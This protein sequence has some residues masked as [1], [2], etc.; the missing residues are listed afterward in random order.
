MSPST[1]YL[2]STGRGGAGNIRPVTK[3]S[4]SPTISLEPTSA[5]SSLF[6]GIGGAGNVVSR[7]EYDEAQR[8]ASLLSSRPA[9]L[10]S[11]ISGRSMFGIGGRGNSVSNATCS[12]KTGL[13]GGEC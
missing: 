3:A 7:N 8:S 9:S 6:R 2:R 12:E 4:T 11:L 5:R 13:E 1:T 10:K